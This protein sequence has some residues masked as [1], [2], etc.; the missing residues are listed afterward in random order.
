M[1]RYF[2]NL[3]HSTERIADDD[4]VDL[5]DDGA[6]TLDAFRAVAELSEEQPPGHWDGWKIEVVDEENRVVV[7]V[8][9]GGD[10]RHIRFLNYGVLNAERD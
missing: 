5:P 1:P 4:G 8:D 2:F 7:I 9:L 6:V 3:V 10:L